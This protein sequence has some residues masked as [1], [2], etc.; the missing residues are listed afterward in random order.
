MLGS[1]LPYRMA[2]GGKL[3]A[4]LR[5]RSDALTGPGPSILAHA[6]SPTAP[7]PLLKAVLK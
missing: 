5:S 1:L 6:V 2:P 7:P 4:L 3:C